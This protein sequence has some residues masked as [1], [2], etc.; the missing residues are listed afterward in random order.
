MNT[1]AQSKSSASALSCDAELWHPH[2]RGRSV[3]AHVW[4]RTVTTSDRAEN[5]SE[6]AAVPTCFFRH[7]AHA[8][9]HPHHSDSPGASAP[10]A[11]AQAGEHDH[12]DNRASEYSEPCVRS[13]HARVRAMG[14]R[15]TA[16]QA[17][18]GRI[19][20]SQ[21]QTPGKAGTA[22]NGHN[23]KLSVENVIIN[24]AEVYQ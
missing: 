16:R 19:M 14:G 3:D 17:L 1:W 10:P 22:S 8:A 4:F 18:C 7:R 11:S 5:T 2:G 21:P 9:R 20:R 24:Y 12:H 6:E 23:I 15:A 13:Q